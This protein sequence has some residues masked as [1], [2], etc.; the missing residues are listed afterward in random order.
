MTRFPGQDTMTRALSEPFLLL[1][2]PQL[3][4]SSFVQQIASRSDTLVAVSRETT[5]G[6]RQEILR[7]AAHLLQ[8]QGYD[9]T[10]LNDVAAAL[11]LSKG[12]CIPTFRA[13]TKSYLT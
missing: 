4:Q 8:Q 12:G 11:K 10:P 5:Q 9:A 2:R 7:A 6:S 3:R 1:F 13:R